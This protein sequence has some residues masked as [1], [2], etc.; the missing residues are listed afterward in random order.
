MKKKVIFYSL[1]CSF[2][3]LIYLFLSAFDV[4]RWINFALTSFLTVVAPFVDLAFENSENIRKKKLSAIKEL[5]RVCDLIDDVVDDGVKV[6]LYRQRQGT[7]PQTNISVVYSQIWST[8]I[9]QYKDT[10]YKSVFSFLKDKKKALEITNLWYSKKLSLR[11]FT[12]ENLNKLNPTP[13][14][15]VVYEIPAKYLSRK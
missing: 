3:V 7:M 10:V 2:S 13:S 14:E 6:S 4:D 5:Y 9:S 8:T 1:Y 15:F 11:N 12:T